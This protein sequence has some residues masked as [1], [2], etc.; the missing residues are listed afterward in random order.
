MRA[1]HRG[2][3]ADQNDWIK[4]VGGPSGC[5]G[6]CPA[7][8]KPGVFCVAA[9]NTVGCDTE[10][11]ACYETSINVSNGIR[12]A[13]ASQVGTTDLDPVFLDILQNLI[14][15]FECLCTIFMF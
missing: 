11:A 15:A 6:V 3:G 12:V 1:I 13:M 10:Y 14:S 5:S 7:L 2:G 8:L 9:P 4:A